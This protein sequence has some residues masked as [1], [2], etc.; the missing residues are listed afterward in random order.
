MTTARQTDARPVLL[1][2]IDG[3]VLDSAPGIVRSL[4]AAMTDVGLAPASEEQLRSDLG[5]PPGIM[6]AGVGVP[7]HLIQDGVIAYRRRYQQAGMDDADVFDGIADTLTVLGA[8]YRLATATMKLVDT[9]T[10]FLD[11]HRLRDHFE[12]I[13]GARNGV[14]EKAAIIAETRSRLGSPAAE[15]MIMIGDRHSDIT[16]G[17]LNGLGTI[18]VTWGYG[19]RAELESAEPD[20]MVDRP[21]ELVEAVSRLLA[22]A[23]A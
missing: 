12:L 22:H 16:G 4:R 10:E 6:L 8:A 19:S 2:D 13:G 1:F 9:A 23:L 15:N 5:P 17:R 3:T 20:V 7:E 18:A 11:R 21:D 14:F